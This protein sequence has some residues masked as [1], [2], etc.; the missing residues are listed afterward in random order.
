MKIAIATGIY[1]PEIGGPAK[2]AKNLAETWRNSGNEVS[3]TIFSRLNYLPTGIRHLVYFL[4]LIPVV[5]K[6]DFVLALDTYSAALPALCAAKLLGKIIIIRTGGDFLWESY[7]E[8]TGDLVLLRDFYKVSIPKFNFKE[9]I[10][11]FLTKFILNNVD[12]LVWSTK[13]QKEIFELPYELSKQKNFIIENYYGTKHE[14]LLPQKKNFISFARKLKWKNLELLKKVFERSDVKTVGAILETDNSNKH[15][16]DEILSSS[17]A[18]IITSLG[19]ISPNTILDAISYNKPFILTK[20][21]GLTERIKDIGIFVD[22]KNENEIAEKIIWLSQ[23]ENYDT[24]KRK[25]ESFSFVHDWQEMVNE[26]IDVYNKI[27]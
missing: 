5:Y 23:K 21:N 27:R 9:K 22:P 17:Y 14:S 11:F 7:V 26:Y 13:W 19:D 3:V 16:F 25:I 15:K 10:I 8:R 18:V 24:Q 6:A 12:A 1:P 4:R 20:E 2:Y